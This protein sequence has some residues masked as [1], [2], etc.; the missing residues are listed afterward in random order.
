M[1]KNSTQKGIGNFASK[2]S[3]SITMLPALPA[4]LLVAG[5]SILTQCNKL[6]Q[7]QT[8]SNPKTFDSFNLENYYNKFIR[9]IDSFLK[10]GDSYPVC[11]SKNSAYLPAYFYFLDDSQAHSNFKPAL[12]K[13]L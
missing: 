7:H 1:N 6:F 13:Q 10:T 9:R 11:I 2:I 3:N 8:V 4:N 5:N 12:W